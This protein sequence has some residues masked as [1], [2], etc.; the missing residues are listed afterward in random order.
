MENPLVRVRKIL[1]RVRKSSV[2]EKNLRQ[3]AM[4]FYIE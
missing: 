4:Q 2:R 3:R 1:V